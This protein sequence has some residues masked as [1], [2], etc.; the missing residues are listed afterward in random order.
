MSTSN[1]PNNPESVQNEI[2]NQNESIRQN[3]RETVQLSK[4]TL[5]LLTPHEE[6]Q[7][8]SDD[9]DEVEDE[10]SHWHDNF[11]A[12]VFKSIGD[13]Q[14]TQPRSTNVDHQKRQK[15]PYIHR[16]QSQADRKSLDCGLSE[17]QLAAPYIEEEQ[18]EK[19]E[20]FKR[21]STTPLL[22]SE[23]QLESSE[24]EGI[25]IYNLFFFS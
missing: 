7:S 11:F 4:S 1:E 21:S 17:H 12:N 6:E 10:S 3:P 19:P 22:T 13:N 18:P 9:E 24:A 2:S 14:P 16:L 8:P 15:R 23:E 20:D 5:A 25:F